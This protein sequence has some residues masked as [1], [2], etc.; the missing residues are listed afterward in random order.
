MADV[1]HAGADEHLL[2]RVTSHLAE[3]LHVVGVVGAGHHR[4]G[5]LVEVD[6]QHFRVLRV[7][8]STHQLGVRQPGL[9]LLDPA[10]QG[11][12]VAV[13][14]G[15]HVF[16]Q[17]HVA[18]Q[19]FAHR[20]FGELDRAA[21]AGA[22]GAGIGEFEGLFQLQ[23]GQT[24]DLHDP[25]VEQVLLVGLFN[26]EQSPL[27]GH[28][29]DGVHHVPERDA[30]LQGS[31]EAHQHRFRHVQWHGADGGRKGHHPRAAWEGNAEGEAGVAVA[32]GADGVGQKHP[33]Q[34]AVDD[35]VT[36]PKGHATALG[37]EVGQ[38]VLGLQI[39]RLRIGGGV[40]E[41]LHHQ[42]GGE[43]QAGQFLHFVPRHRAGGVL[44]ADGG[45]Q[46]FAAGAGSDA[47]KT[48][49]LAHH[50]LRQGEALAGVCRG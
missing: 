1:G 21:G 9:H 46:R 34:P 29:G 4:F 39:H 18:A 38:F 50:L 32:A 35:A 20:V 33:V 13:A 37:E 19:V 14:A 45:H 3:Q 6:L 30:R 11:A 49:G 24:F 48:A 31:A 25:A 44:G 22:F 23:V 28:P 27:N 12:G 2:H 41:A 26:G 8:V 40:A 17:R 5:E 15:D 7:C 43:A 10:G 42:V 36:G 47:C 16:E